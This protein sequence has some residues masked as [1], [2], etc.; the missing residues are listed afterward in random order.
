MLRLIL[1]SKKG[2]TAV[3]YLLMIALGAS[4]GLAAFKKLKE[5]L[6][7]GPDSVIGKPLKD[8]QTKLSSDERY[9]RAPFRVTKKKF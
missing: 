3:E 7:T 2:Q 8:M 5:Y 1:K 9:R 6:L 4:L